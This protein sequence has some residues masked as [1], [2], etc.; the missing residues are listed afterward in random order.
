MSTEQN[1]A[2]VRGYNDRP[3][4]LIVNSFQHSR[5]FES[6]KCLSRG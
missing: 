2:I 6:G 3:H 4:G 5:S 1:K